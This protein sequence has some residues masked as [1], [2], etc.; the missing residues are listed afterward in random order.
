MKFYACVIPEFLFWV[1]TIFITD[2]FEKNSPIWFKK[3]PEISWRDMNIGL[4]YIN[5]IGNCIN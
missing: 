5:D 4:K 1:W 3:I 2:D